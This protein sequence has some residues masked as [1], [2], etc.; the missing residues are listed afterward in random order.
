MLR[1]RKRE[2]EKSNYD[3]ENGILEFLLQ[4]CIGKIRK[5]GTGTGLKKKQASKYREN[6]NN[7]HLIQGT[8]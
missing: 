5:G 4:F 8:F 3:I 2:R 1:E 7:V 6:L